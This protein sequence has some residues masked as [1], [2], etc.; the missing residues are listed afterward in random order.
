MTQKLRLPFPM[1]S[2]P[3]GDRV[4]RPY[5][6]YNAEER[7]GI[8]HPAVI[9]VRPDGEEAF[10]EVGRDSGDRIAEDDLLD[11]VRGLD[12]PPTQAE[13]VVEGEPRPG[14]RAMPVDA[15]A[16]YF[17]GAKFAVL[18]MGRRFPEAREEAARYAAEAERYMEAAK[19]LR[20]GTGA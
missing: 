11:A 19:R 2:D 10:R 17:R 15:L 16:P 20:S 12:L 6:V 13:E 3:N 5:G 18:N 14:D 4:L 1:L 8:A 9:V 7:G